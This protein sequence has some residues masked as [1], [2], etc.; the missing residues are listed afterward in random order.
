MEGYYDRDAPHERH[1]GALRTGVRV[2]RKHG[3][4]PYARVVHTDREGDA[5]MGEGSASSA[6]SQRV[7]A[8]HPRGG[9]QAHRSRSLS[10]ALPAERNVF[11][12][13]GPRN[14][15]ISRES[16]G[17][18]NRGRARV[19]FT[20]RPPL[21]AWFK[22]RLVGAAT[23]DRTWVMNAIGERLSAENIT[24][25]PIQVAVDGNSLTF[26]VKDQAAANRLR[27]LNKA[28]QFSHGPKMPIA[29]NP[30]QAP[31]VHLDESVKAAIKTAM[32]KRYDAATHS[33]TLSLFNEAPEFKTASLNIQLSRASHMKA[34]L[35]LIEANIKELQSL[36]LSKNRLSQLM[37][38]S[39][40]A[41]KVQ[42]RQ[43]NL[44][45]NA[46]RHIRDVELLRSFIHLV[47]LDLSRNPIRDAYRDTP[48]YIE[49]IRKKLPNL[50]RLDGVDLP[51]K[52]G[53][54]APARI[55]LPVPT[56]FYTPFDAQANQRLESFLLRYYEYFDGRRSE[57][58]G[59]YSE[60]A[61]FSL[62]IPKLYDKSS[63]FYS[64]SRN[65]NNVTESVV[66]NA[67]L[68]LGRTSIV[69]FFGKLPATAHAPKSFTVDVFFNENALL[70]L[71]V[72]GVFREDQHKRQ[73]FR[74]FSRNFVIVISEEGWRIIS[75]TLTVTAPSVEQ[76]NQ[77]RQNTAPENPSNSVAT[78]AP[79]VST[80]SALDEPMKLAMIVNFAN[81]SGMNEQY[82][83]LALEDN[84]WDYAKAGAAFL[85]LKSENKLPPEAFV[86]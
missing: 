17:T 9:Q 13:L 82:S 34:V 29:V 63:G 49:D 1:S 3:A 72:T 52:I 8:F 25:Q 6:T 60:D 64:H 28:I 54:D 76:V 85:Q 53:F 16:F 71:M 55:Q 56:P 43:L 70:G 67:K 69:D 31:V 68:L 75:D 41:D 65:L 51:K 81:E 45:D 36:D 78:P 86:K 10:V 80:A 23:V 40:L 74:S 18:R 44:S 84:Y 61:Q 77:F 46:I 21:T 5:Q 66:Q 12:R 33:L 39:R 19:V 32:G 11:S 14:L 22:V 38:F 4:A 42:L 57:L 35:E 83:R 37:D 2:H 27:M 24:F 62:F 26:Y 15:R 73:Q 47:D 20:S 79:T 7:A 58:L 59:A 30:S 48:A 50:L